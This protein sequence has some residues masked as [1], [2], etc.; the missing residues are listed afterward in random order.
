MGLG[1][2]FE[3]KGGRGVSGKNM[4]DFRRKDPR[5]GVMKIDT[6]LKATVFYAEKKGGFL[7]RKG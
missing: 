4:K 3:E 5:N 6:S 2:G 7:K 1:I